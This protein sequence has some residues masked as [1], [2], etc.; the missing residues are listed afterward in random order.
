MGTLYCIG[1]A[2][3][4]AAGRG[5]PAGGCGA[6]SKLVGRGKPSGVGH[7]D[8]AAAA[9]GWGGGKPPWP[10]DRPTKGEGE[11]GVKKGVRAR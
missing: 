7:K 2:P 1:G 9:A 11:G 4:D 6:K 5:R 3:A 10:V 8:A